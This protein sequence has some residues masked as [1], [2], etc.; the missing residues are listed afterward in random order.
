V[1]DGYEATRRLRE[2]F[3]A[4]ELPIV[5]MTANALKSERDQ[6]LA[7]GMNSYLTKPVHIRTLLTT[8]TE[9]LQSRPAQRDPRV[10]AEAGVAQPG[11]NPLVTALA[12]VA[13]IDL[14]DARER[15]EDNLPLLVTLLRN[16]VD[17][18]ADSATKLVALLNAG[19][20][21][22][23]RSL[24]HGIKGIASNISATGIVAQAVAI[25]A[26][27]PTHREALRQATENLR[28]DFDDLVREVARV[29]SVGS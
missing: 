2:T 14:G 13:G 17:R 25:E 19:E 18:N 8:L 16:F 12:G 5:A 29:L 11:S 1:M 3:S 26:M 24:L 10:E 9:L 4:T 23:F 6:C 28:R 7:L 21:R 27:D 20:M 22:A 15:L